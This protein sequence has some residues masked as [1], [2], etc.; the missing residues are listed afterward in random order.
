M[1]KSSGRPETRVIVPQ[2][3]HTYVTAFSDSRRWDRFEPRRGDIV[4]CTPPKCGTTWTQT[5]CAELLQEC[6]DKGVRCSMTQAVWLDGRAVPHDAALNQLQ[7]AT[8]VRIIKTHTPLSA[9]PYFTEC[10]YVYC[11]RDPRDAFL[12]MLDHLSN[13]ADGMSEKYRRALRL[14][15]G[16]LDANKLFPEWLTQ[17]E[18]SWLEDGFPMG[19]VL[20]HSRTFWEYRSL[21]NFMF[22]HYA[23]MIMNLPHEIGRMIDFLGLSLPS[24][25]MSIVAGRCSFA[26]MRHRADQLAPGARD[27]LWK[28]NALFFRN[29]RLKEWQNILSE[30][31]KR[32]YEVRAGQLLSPDLK[33][34]L[35]EGTSAGK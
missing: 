15:D 27:R 23:D 4:I 9:M 22:L 11:G 35:E 24:P 1:S 33:M 32:L 29:A 14:P 2:R 28:S 20:S 13:V 7:A 26:S 3:L 5:I 30:E 25:T 12:S 19:T 6:S 31:N 10:R 21:P 17:G 34:W 8:G 16:Q 18:V